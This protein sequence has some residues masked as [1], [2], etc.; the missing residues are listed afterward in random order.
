MSGMTG[1]ALLKYILAFTVGLIGLTFY[2]TWLYN[3]VPNSLIPM[4]IVHFTLNFSIGLAGPDGLGLAQGTPLMAIFGGLMVLTDLILW[5]VARRP[6]AERPAT[7]A[8]P[9]NLQ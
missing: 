1:V 9:Q 8:K 2:M 3:K 5:T 7:A 4:I 6:A